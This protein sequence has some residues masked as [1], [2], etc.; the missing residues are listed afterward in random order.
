MCFFKPAQHEYVEQ[1]EPIS[2][3]RNLRGLKYSFQILTQL[4][5]RNNV[6]HAAASNLDGFLLDI[7]GFLQFTWMCLFE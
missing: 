4:S 3:L 2:T 1:G 6:L 7:H 5:Q